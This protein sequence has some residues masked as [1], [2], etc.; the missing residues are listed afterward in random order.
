M[1][2]GGAGMEWSIQELAKAAGTTSRA[3]RYYG[4]RGLLT[5]TSTGANG[6]S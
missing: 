5:P 3:L 6:M 1:K 4:E 2:T